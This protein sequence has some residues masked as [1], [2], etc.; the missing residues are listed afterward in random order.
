MPIRCF[1]IPL[2]HC[3]FI[4]NFA[5]TATEK[6][7]SLLC[8]EKSKRWMH[9]DTSSQTMYYW[10]FYCALSEH[11]FL[12]LTTMH[13][14]I[15]HHVTLTLTLLLSG[16]VSMLLNLKTKLLPGP[17]NTPNAFLCRLCISRCVSMAVR[18]S[19]FDDRCQS[20]RSMNVAWQRNSATMTGRLRTRPAKSCSFTPRIKSRTFLSSDME[21]STRRN[22]QDISSTNTG[23]P[24][25]GL[26]FCDTR[27]CLASLFF[28][29]LL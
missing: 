14:L 23:T 6:F 28:S 11:I 9:D 19:N 1:V 22:S 8:R 24:S 17:D 27:A 12:R 21:E 29:V 2:C 13:V 10:A 15:T 5:Q 20:A 16:M 3:T 26:W 18:R 25:F 4:R 7:W